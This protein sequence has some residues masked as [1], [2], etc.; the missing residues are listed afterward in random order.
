MDSDP[1]YISYADS[2]SVL[3]SDSDAEDLHLI[4]ILRPSRPHQDYGCMGEDHYFENNDLTNSF[5]SSEWKEEYK[6]MD[7]IQVTGA[8]KRQ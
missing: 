4:S 2:A 8:I 6:D 1:D 5:D 3:D 7:E